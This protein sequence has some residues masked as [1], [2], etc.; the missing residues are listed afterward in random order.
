MNRPARWAFSPLDYAAHLLSDGDQPLGVLKAR[1]GH[2]LPMVAT[3]CAQP[4]GRKC[5]PCELIFRADLDNPADSADPHDPPESPPHHR[6]LLPG[7][8]EN[9]HR[10]GAL[11]SARAEHGV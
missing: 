11:R 9:Y 1:C 2:L 10:L 6:V 3:E 7:E 5:P 8:P 4:P